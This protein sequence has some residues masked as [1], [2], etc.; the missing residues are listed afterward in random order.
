VSSCGNWVESS[1]GEE[2]GQGERTGFFAD[3]PRVFLPYYERLR[4]S[5]VVSPA[6]GIWHI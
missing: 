5:D 1:E 6:S 2:K 3:V 4:R